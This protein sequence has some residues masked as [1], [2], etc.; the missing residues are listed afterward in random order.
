M[1]KMLR[2]GRL[3]R[4]LLRHIGSAFTWGVQ[5]LPSNDELARLYPG[6]AARREICPVTFEE[7]THRAVSTCCKNSF[8]IRGI[9]MAALIQHRCPMCR[10]SE[11]GIVCAVDE[12]KL[13]SEGDCDFGHII[14]G[15]LADIKA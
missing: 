11:F 12:E 7:I 5:T 4:A 13:D 3:S 15:L 2:E 6:D 14:G 1:M 10:Q 9:A 8:D